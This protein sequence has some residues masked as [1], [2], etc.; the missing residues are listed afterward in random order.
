MN[1]RVYD[2]ELGRFMSADPF[3]QAPYNSQSYNRY[4][5]TFN[6]PLSYTDPSG[7][8]CVRWT[9]GNDTGES[10]S[11]SSGC[12]GGSHDTGLGSNAWYWS[13]FYQQQ[14]QQYQQYQQQL[15]NYSQL[16]RQI[17]GAPHYAQ[18]QHL[19]DQ[20]AKMLQAEIVLGATTF[21]VVGEGI[22]AAKLLH[23]AKK[24]SDAKKAADALIIK[25]DARKANDF[26]EGTKY[27]NKVKGQM[28][29]DDYH[30]FPES[31]KGFQDSRKISKLNG[32][33]GVVRDKLEIPGSYRG[34]DG[35]F[36]F[37]KEP[38]NTINHRLFRPNNRE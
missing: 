25:N 15:Q 22:L 11:G 31:V 8:Q 19:L 4:S 17:L 37:I 38:D 16:S 7:Y 12:D 13:N 14:Q 18:G 33:D 3:V 32:G 34:Q 36:E 35:R 5:Y 28:K 24:V 20:D 10:A 26:F 6:N 27:T 9:T 30:S 29:Q 21:V 1:G 2:P 23:D